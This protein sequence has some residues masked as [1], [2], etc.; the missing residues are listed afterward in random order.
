[1]STM[2]PFSV[3]HMYIQMSK[4]LILCCKT[5]HMYAHEWL[6]RRK[7]MANIFSDSKSF[8]LYSPDPDNLDMNTIYTYTQFIQPFQRELTS[9]LSP[10]S[11]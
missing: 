5:I 10:F 8:M 1:M 7:S 11:T 2:N 4:D 9:V 6:E 3:L